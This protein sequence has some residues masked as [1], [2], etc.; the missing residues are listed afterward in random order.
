M[1]NVYI[2]LREKKYTVEIRSTD[3]H[4]IVVYFPRLC[5]RT[6]A[7]KVVQ[8]AEY[9]AE[10]IMYINVYTHTR[11]RA[12]A[13]MGVSSRAQIVYCIIHTLYAANGTHHTK[14]GRGRDG[15]VKKR[16]KKNAYPVRNIIRQTAQEA[17]R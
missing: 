14:S 4:V 3:R 17:A 9:P 7:L 12:L 5:R 11:A 2:T 16:K 6:D 8:K 13:R 10:Y 1:Y 15:C